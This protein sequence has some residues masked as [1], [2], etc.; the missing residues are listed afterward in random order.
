MSE[1]TQVPETGSMVSAVVEEVSQV[2]QKSSEEEQRAQGEVQEAGE[3]SFSQICLPLIVVA[4]VL[5]GQVAT[6]LEST[7]LA[8]GSAQLK[9]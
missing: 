4:N 5:A 7:L 2:R 1:L 8:F 3:L 6:Q 9:H